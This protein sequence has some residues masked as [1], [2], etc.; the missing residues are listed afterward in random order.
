ML[1]GCNKS[2][3]PQPN[4]WYGTYIIVYVLDADK[5][6]LY[7]SITNLEDIPVLDLNSDY[8]LQLHVGPGSGLLPYSGASVKYNENEVV[9]QELSECE[10]ELYLLRGLK[11]CEFSELEIMNLATI[12]EYKLQCNILVSFSYL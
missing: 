11:E 6:E 9:V 7:S 1:A 10:G 12:P 4:N 8:Y 2:D 5:K 3:N